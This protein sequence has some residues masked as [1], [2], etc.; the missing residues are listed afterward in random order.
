MDHGNN[1]KAVGER[2]MNE[3]PPTKKK[4]GTFLDVEVMSPVHTAPHLLQH[5]RLF[6]PDKAGHVVD[7]LQS[8]G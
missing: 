8:S 7:L 2:N 5:L 1:Q 4:L 6:F 3:K